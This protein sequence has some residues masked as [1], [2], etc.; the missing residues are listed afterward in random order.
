MGFGAR[1][2]EL[3]M[4]RAIISLPVPLSPWMS[5]V[6]RRLATS[7]HSSRMSRMRAFLVIDI[8]H[9]VLAAQF[10]A[11]DAVFALQV[12]HLHDAVDQQRNLFRI[13]RLD[14]IL[15]RALLHRRDGRVHRG[16]GGDD[17]DGSLRADAADLHHRLDA[18]HSARHLQVDEINGV[19]AL[20][21][22]LDGFVPRRRGVHRVAVFAQP[23]GQRFAHHLFVVYYQDLPAV[24]HP[25]TPLVLANRARHG[26]QKP[27][28]FMSICRILV[29]RD[30]AQLRSEQ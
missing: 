6:L 7:W 12:L 19:V 15:L 25:T 23:R 5:T 28:C 11:Q 29:A 8:V 22:L 21:C 10:L 2:P 1:S 24:L 20:A 17:D 27:A 16:I 3:W 14:D 13:A 26:A 9:Y 18:V 4:A 30:M